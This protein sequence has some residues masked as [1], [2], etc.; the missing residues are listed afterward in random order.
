M[1]TLCSDTRREGGTLQTTPHTT[2]VLADRESALGTGHIRY[3]LS[4]T[5][6]GRTLVACTSL[7]VCL[8][9]LGDDDAD[10]IA[11][12][13]SRFADNRIEPDSGEFAEW[14]DRARSFIDGGIGADLPLPPLDL[15]GTPFQH[16][17]W[18]ALRAIPLGQTRTYSQL[19]AS[20]GRPTATR[21]VASACGANPVAVLVPCHRVIAADGS[22]GGYRWGLARK[23]ALLERE[24]AI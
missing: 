23:R 17:V 5:T 24:G 1:L 8:V 14:T 21:A 6:L 4:D 20:I 10:L 15:H 7:G 3:S 11:Q 12:A 22:L 19:A 9:A 16:T 13:R 2:V 18:D